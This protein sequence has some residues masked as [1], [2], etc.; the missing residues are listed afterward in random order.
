MQVV[1]E[2]YK[3]PSKQA[4]TG[5]LRLR[6]TPTVDRKATHTPERQQLHCPQPD[7]FTY[8]PPNNPCYHLRAQSRSFRLHYAA[9][10]ER[11]SGAH[12]RAT[13]MPPCLSSTI[14]RDSS[15]HCM[16]RKCATSAA[17]VRRRTLLVSRM[18]RQCSRQQRFVS[19][20]PL[21]NV[22]AVR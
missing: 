21:Q 9:A 4:C 17:Q 19:H 5:Y 2:A 3:H 20:K 14:A 16:F 6:L 10:Y 12:G 7:S 22:R 13:R 18:C 1:S 8:S 11:S 15:A